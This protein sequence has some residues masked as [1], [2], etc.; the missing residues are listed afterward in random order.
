MA[1]STPYHST[2]GNPVR[3]EGER[4]TGYI[5]RRVMGI[6]PVMLAVSLIVFTLIRIVPGDVVDLMMGGVAT[7]GGAQEAQVAKNLRAELG[8]DKPLPVQYLDWLGKTVRGDLG[9]SVYR[10]RPVLGEVLIAAPA[11]FELAILSVIISLFISLPLGIISAVKQDSWIDNL[12]KTTAILGLSLPT[13]WT[14]TMIVVFM[15]LWFG[16][17]P[18]LQLASPFQDPLG[19]FQKMIFPAAVLAVVLAGSI[20]RMIRSSLLEVLRQDYMRTAHAKGLRQATVVIRHGLK[21]AMIPVVTVMGLQFASLL[22]G[23]VIVESIFTVP[24]LGRLTVGAIQTRDYPVLQG[25]VLVFALIL[26]LTNLFVDLTYS[27]LDPRIR[28]GQKGS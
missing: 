3:I 25:T 27:W 15:G 28:Y 21:N 5:I 4:L 9:N 17:S 18:P 16:Y 2:H 23:T 1:A 12:A 20:A 13:F 22:G 19:N 7:G 10:H 6:F 24:G 26:L 11:T 8:L 14:G